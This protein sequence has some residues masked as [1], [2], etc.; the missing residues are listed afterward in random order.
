MSS[1]KRRPRSKGVAGDV[2]IFVATGTALLVIVAM[3][4]F[5][6]MRHEPS[7]GTAAAPAVAEGGYQRHP[8]A[9]PDSHTA[10]PDY[11]EQAEIADLYAY[12]LANPDVLT[13]IPCTCGCG[14]MGH[15]SNYNCYVREVAPDGSVTFDPHATGCE[16]C[17]LITRDVIEMRARGTPLN[18]IRDYVDANYGGVPTDTEYPPVVQ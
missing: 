10:M 2:W 4:A 13:Y 15:L 14:S 3:V 11:A 18:E 17:I 8:M 6:A 16:T 7:N 1:A 5:V 12:A 9:M